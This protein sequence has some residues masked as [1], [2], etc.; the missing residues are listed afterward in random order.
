MNVR[1][2]PGSSSYEVPFRI[3]GTLIGSV[4]LTSTG[5]IKIVYILPSKEGR[6]LYELTSNGLLESL[7]IGWNAVPKGGDRD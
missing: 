3:N 1:K 4:E 2:I 6:D 7:E 5:C